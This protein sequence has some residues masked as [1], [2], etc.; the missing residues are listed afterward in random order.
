MCGTEEC[1]LLSL[2]LLE[3]CQILHL[4]QAM[5]V[6]ADQQSMLGM[7]LQPLCA[8]HLLGCCS[9]RHGTSSTGL[10]PVNALTFSDH[11]GLHG[12]LGST[13]QVPEPVW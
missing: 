9:Q 5:E 1:H 4:H 10:A 11:Y 13:A 7:L 3:A 8:V 2:R 6:H 12:C